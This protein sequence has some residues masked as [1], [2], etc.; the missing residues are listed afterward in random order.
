MAGN[1]G[2]KSGSSEPLG[3]ADYQWSQFDPEAYF[4]HYYGDPH[5]DDDRVAQAAA[6]ALFDCDPK[7]RELDIIDVGTGPNLIPFL[8]GI[9]RARSLTA[10]EFSPTNIDWLQQELQRGEL[11]PQWQHF[12]T[13]IKGSLAGVPLPDDPAL[14]LASKARIVR[15]SIFDLPEREWDAA[16]MFFCAESITQ[17]VSEFSDACAKF[18]KCVRPG[19]T[20]AAAFLVQSHGYD[21]AGKRF[22]A[23][24]L[25]PEAIEGVF[26]KL[27]RQVR[28]AKIGLVSEEVRSGYSGALFL[29]A[30]T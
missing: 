8:A 1:D 17:Q 18:A 19:G 23:I 14:A 2:L 30:K 5:P 15:G 7:T 20:L 10:W 27:A 22:P 6:E 3:N 16:T 26:L 21:V 29:T 11:R 28:V 4:L 9:S 25:S 12:W 13:A 24:N